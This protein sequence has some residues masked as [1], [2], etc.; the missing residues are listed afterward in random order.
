MWLNVAPMLTQAV[1][2]RFVQRWINQ[3][4]AKISQLCH[5]V[6]N[7]AIYTRTSRKTSWRKPWRH[8]KDRKKSL[9]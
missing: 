1:F 9:R 6:T 7:V 4:G 2:E 5:A 8:D 3:L